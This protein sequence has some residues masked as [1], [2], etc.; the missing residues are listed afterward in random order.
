MQASEEIILGNSLVIKEMKKLIEMVSSSNTTV[1]IQ[2]ETGTGKE[3]VAEALHV[4]SGR[5]GNNISVNCAAIP[6]ELLESELF[7]HEKGAFTGADRLRV[8]RFEQ[9]NDGT[10]FLDEIGDMPLPLQSK[11]LRVLEGRKIQRVG[12]SKEVDVNF[13]L[14]CATHQDLDKKVEKGEFRADLFYRI[15]VFPIDVPTLAARKVD[16]PVLIQGIIEKIKFS[17]EEIKV[18]FSDDAL[19]VLSNYNWPGNVRELRNVIER[20]AVLFNDRSVSGEN[21]KE[22]LLK[23]KVPDP[24]EEQ[25]ELWAA[26][27]DLVEATNDENGKELESLPIPKPEQYKDWFLYY[28]KMDL[29][30]HLSEIEIV[31]IEAALEK[32]D[33]MVS[34]ASDALKLRR[35]TL[36]E[37]MKKYGISK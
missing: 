20:A 12:S 24:D 18:N 4:A 11:L 9:A 5:K 2:G 19:K 8:G 21:V 14:V 30:R 27:T 15:N 7:G 10:I 26:T 6:S 34:Q 13:R 29:R 33:G 32:T 28:D 1:L 3:L 16:V 25:D 36:I 17:G 31:M 23:L 22:N 35:T 37:K